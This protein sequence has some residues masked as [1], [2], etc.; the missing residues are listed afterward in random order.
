MAGACAAAPAAWGPSS[1]TPSPHPLQ[2]GT[3]LSLRAVVVFDELPYVAPPPPPLPN[4]LAN[5]RAT[6]RYVRMALHTAVHT[7][8]K[9]WSVPLEEADV[10]A[11]AATML[12]SGNEEA[13]GMP[14]ELPTEAAA[15][16]IEAVAAAAGAG[17]T[18]GASTPGT[19]AVLGTS[20][21]D[22]NR[23]SSS[24]MRHGSIDLATAY[25]NEEARP[26]MHAVRANWRSWVAVRD[27]PCPGHFWR[28]PHDMLTYHYTSDKSI[29][30]EALR[31]R[32]L[33]PEPA[34]PDRLLDGVAVGST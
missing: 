21:P 27:A 12:D 28:F 32:G 24:S 13:H 11:A 14:A 19:A 30:M 5:D 8:S 6:Q 26:C 31:A 10:E 20:P 2:L 34:S 22:L 18:D 17:A 33:L 25:A 16:V 29:L 23:V 3:W 4:P 1:G 7:T 9:R 15:V